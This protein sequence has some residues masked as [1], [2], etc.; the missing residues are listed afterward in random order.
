MVIVKSGC[1]ENKIA[2]VQ[3]QGPL[4]KKSFKKILVFLN[5]DFLIFKILK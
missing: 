1:V 3:V 2:E 4:G 5:F